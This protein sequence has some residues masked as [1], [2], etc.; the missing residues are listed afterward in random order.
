[1]QHRRV[2]P[3]DVLDVAVFDLSRLR[4]VQRKVMR[5]KMTVGDGVIVAGF[6][7][8]DVLRGQRRRERQKRRNEQESGDA[9]QP[10]HV[11]IIGGM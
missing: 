2:E 7:L 8:V 4:L 10:D 1:M 9:G 11:G 6:R 5:R 3:N